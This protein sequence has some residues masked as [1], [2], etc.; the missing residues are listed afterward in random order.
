[1]E[2]KKENV[3]EHIGRKLSIPEEVYS[4]V[5]LLHTHIASS[6]RSLAILQH[7]CCP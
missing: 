2:Y 1:M 5:Q 4:T 6:M 7:R 3:P